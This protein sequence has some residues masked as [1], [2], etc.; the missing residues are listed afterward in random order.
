LVYGKLL[1]A[2]SPSALSTGELIAT[3]V[4]FW[5]VYLA[6]FGAWVRHIARAVRNGPDEVPA[7]NAHAAPDRA[8]TPA[9]PVP[10]PA[11]AAGE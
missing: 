6:L 10:T 3:L 5:V 11:T 8:P 4:T 2:N 7:R 9:L 1:V